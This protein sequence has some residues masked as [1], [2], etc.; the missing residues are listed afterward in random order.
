MFHL[1]SIQAVS[2]THL[3][4]ASIDPYSSVATVELDGYYSL[5]G[6]KTNSYKFSE[7]VDVLLI[8]IQKE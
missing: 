3:G 2:Y 7:N 5:G 6:Q 4:A 8:R 1:L